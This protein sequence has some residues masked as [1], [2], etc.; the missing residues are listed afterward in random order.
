MVESPNEN[1]IRDTP[2]SSKVF[3]QVIIVAIPALTA[4]SLYTTTQLDK[5]HAVQEQKI[6]TLQKE[7]EDMRRYVYG[8]AHNGSHDHKKK[9]AGKSY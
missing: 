2:L 6:I 7:V 4:W 3:A 9:K 1:T 5:K 8:H